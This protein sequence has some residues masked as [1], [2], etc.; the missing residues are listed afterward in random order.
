M[1]EIHQASERQLIMVMR[2]QSLCLDIIL[3]VVKCRFVII[4]CKK[5]S[6]KEL[7]V[8]LFFVLVMQQ[9]Y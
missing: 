4:V 9:T 1:K 5:E 2:I 7:I 3:A 6:S 8:K